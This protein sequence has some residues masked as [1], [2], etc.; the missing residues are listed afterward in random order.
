MVPGSVTDTVTAPGIAVRSNSSTW[1]RAR[2]LPRAPQMTA[3]LRPRTAAIAAVQYPLRDGGRLVGAGGGDGRVG[4]GR[5][6][7]IEEV[8]EVRLPCPRLSAFASSLLWAG[9]SGR[10]RSTLPP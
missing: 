2:I 9:P 5:R 8:I 1:S 7:I 10:S 4:G 6:S 3:T